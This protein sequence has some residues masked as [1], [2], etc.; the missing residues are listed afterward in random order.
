MT[1][2]FYSANRKRAEAHK[3]GGGPPTPPL[4]DAEELALSQNTGRPEAE[5]I[6]GEPLNSQDTTAYIN[7]NESYRMHHIKKMAKTDKE[8]GGRLERQ[9]RKLKYWNAS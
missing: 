4:T 8:I 2:E 9:I 6:S 3:T 5:V 7:L 1:Y